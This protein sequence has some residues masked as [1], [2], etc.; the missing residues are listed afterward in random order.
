MSAVAVALAV[1]AALIWWGIVLAPWRPWSV[2]ERL[3][4]S[5]DAGGRD[6]ADVTA[7][8]PARDEA[9]T[10]PRTLA[11]LAKQGGAL[12]VVVIDDESG[13]AT[14]RVARTAGAE[15]IAGAPLPADW[16]G[17]LWALEQG[18]RIARTRWVLLLD[19][20]IELRPG[21]LAVLMA[22]A[23]DRGLQLVSVMA[24][25][26][27]ETFWERLLMPAFIFFFKLLYPFA[28][29]NSPRRRMAAAA[30]GCL[31]LERRVI[32]EI[33]GFGAFKDALIDDCALARAVK[34]R[35]YA[36]WV[37]LTHAAVSRRAYDSLAPIWLMVARTAFT[38]L[39]CSGTLLALCS[40]VLG[41]ACWMP[42]AGLFVPGARWAAVCAWVAIA[43][44]YLPTLRFYGRAPWWW[45]AMPLIGTLY[46]VMTWYSAWRYW[47]G[48]AS[49]W[50]GR[51]YQVV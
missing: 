8:I 46:L 9:E 12:R 37:G 14:A 45:L 41:I 17:K 51:D 7:L 50:K 44:S 31:L 15:V 20:D 48:V 26:R 19:A 40:L 47:R 35:G 23:E 34:S 36:T 10:L 16:S 32:D 22:L 42:V 13:D 49:R 39:R 33:G 25:L 3:D 21:A 5:P 11:A 27:M 2:R 4:A 24:R 28:L 1:V 18:R 30:G 6:Y 43:A 38:Q 29:A